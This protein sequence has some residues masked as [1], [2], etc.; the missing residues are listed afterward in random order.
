M[1]AALDSDPTRVACRHCLAWEHL[2]A[3]DFSL[4]ARAAE[5][6]LTYDYLFHVFNNHLM[7]AGMLLSWL[8]TRSAGLNYLPYMLTLLAF[9]ALLS[10]AFYRLLRQLIGA[11]WGL[12]LPFCILVFN[13]I[14]L[15]PTSWWSAGIN[16]LPMQL[17][18]VLAVGAQ[19]KYIRTGRLRHLIT[20]GLAMVLGLAFFE[21]SVL[22]AGLVFLV[23]VCL[24]VRGGAVRSVVRGVGRVLASVVDA[25]GLNWWLS[26]VLLHPRYVLITGAELDRRGGHVRAPDVWL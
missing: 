6:G 16:I 18:M 8:I 24:F 11:R 1:A 10:V 7:P 25:H 19:V 15:E 4:A 14:T 22:I 5:S 9:Q 3:D 26:G 2:T 17:A 23:T 12:L 20:L 21:K 13:P